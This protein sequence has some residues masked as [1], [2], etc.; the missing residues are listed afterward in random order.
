MMADLRRPI[1]NATLHWLRAAN[2]PQAPLAK[3]T[4]REWENPSGHLPGLDPT[5]HQGR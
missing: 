3:H 1:T 4:T 2:Q 5:L